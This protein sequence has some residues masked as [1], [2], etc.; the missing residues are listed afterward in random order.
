MNRLL[1]PEDPRNTEFL[2][3]FIQNG[4]RV[5]NAESH[6]VARDGSPRIF[7][8][9]M[10]GILQEGQVLGAW[11]TQRDVTEQRHIE[12]IRRAEAHA[13]FLSEASA[14]LASSLDYESTLRNVARLAVPTLADWC[15][16]ELAQPDGT[17]QRVETVTSS[18]EDAELARQARELGLEKEPQAEASPARHAFVHG[19]ST[20]VQDITPELLRASARTD[21]H[22]RLLNQ[23][24]ICSFIAV[25]LM[26]RGHA[27]GSAQLLQL[28]F[29]PALHPVELGLLEELARRAALARGERAAVPGGAGGHAPARRVPLHRQPR[30][31]DAAHAAAA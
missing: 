22:L 23:A 28:P 8:N 13:R 1:V 7:L 15:V 25:P 5:E 30:A 24:H 10:V 2:R 19:R 6:E 12:E 14:V 16:V 3:A 20:L 9:N 21:A 11:G 31:E 26:A 4:Y 29:R 17:L 18:P 27:I